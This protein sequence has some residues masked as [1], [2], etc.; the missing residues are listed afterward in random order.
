MI[1]K[2]IVGT[3]RTINSKSDISVHM[4]NVINNIRTS[5]TEIDRMVKEATKKLA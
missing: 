4:R 3:K 2:L 5:S 1:E